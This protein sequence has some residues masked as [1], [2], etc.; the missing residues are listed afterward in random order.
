MLRLLVSACLAAVFCGVCFAQ[1]SGFR[2]PFSSALEKA[3]QARQGVK[4]DP[5]M[6][7]L[8]LMRFYFPRADVRETPGVLS[9]ILR[10]G[11][12]EQH[13]HALS[14]YLFNMYVSTAAYGVD[15]P[16]ELT[17]NYLGVLDG[18]GLL[19]ERFDA[20]RSAAFYEKHKK[21][22]KKK[23]KAFFAQSNLPVY[24]GGD[25]LNDRREHA[26]LRVLERSAYP[27]VPAG[28]RLPR[29]NLLRGAVRVADKELL[30]RWLRQSLEQGKNK[31]VVFERTKV[32]MADLD[33]KYKKTKGR[34]ERLY[35]CVNDECEY[36]SY[37]FGSH[38]CGE[39]ASTRQPWGLMR[40]YKVV[41]RPISGEFL[42]PARA[43][44]FHLADGSDA[45]DWRYHTAML[46]IMNRD[47]RFTPVVA[48]AFLGGQTPVAF[49]EW[50]KHFSAEETVFSASPF[51]RTQSV[52][53]AIK[54]PQSRAGGKVVVAGKTFEP[55][56]VFK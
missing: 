7:R 36:W 6:N 21:E 28:Y 22:I 3:V 56:P 4:Q 41:A 11:V 32:D 50:A 26:F 35:R 44:R 24:N 16:N 39:I 52:E 54:T 15:V 47:G 27:G 18:F 29:T 10:L 14:F 51:T 37:L 34:T 8:H 48:D 40:V 43:E 38:V 45:P 12:S 1:E 31:V 30:A 33:L 20:A 9:G 46:L 13:V 2:T 23:L 53:E 17:F 5:G 19:S 25:A 55:Y 42:K 49:E